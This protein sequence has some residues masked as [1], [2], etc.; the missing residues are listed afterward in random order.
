MIEG[1]RGALKRILQQNQ[2]PKSVPQIRKELAG[3]FRISLKDL[4]V[5]LG[6]MTALGE[7]FTWPQ[8]K[9]WDR[10]PR[11]VLP[12]L[13]LSVVTKC[14]V[15]SASKIKTGLKLPLEM[16]ETALNE[17]ADRGRLYLWQPG[18]ALYFCLSEPRKMAL[19]TTLNALAAG[20]L[21]ETELI[22]LLR[23]RLP[24]YRA[25]D[26]K[27]LLSYSKRVYEYPKYG[28]VKTKYGLEPPEPG[29]YLG[30]AMQEIVAVQRLLAHFQISLEAIHHALGRELGLEHATREP[31]RE[32]PKGEIASHNAE[33]FILEAITRV[34]PSG[35]RR[36]LVSVRELRRSVSLPKNVFDR[37][38][39]SL[40]LQGKVA[41][42]HHDFPS[43]LSQDERD[44]LVRDQE[45]TYYVG[46]VP[47][48]TP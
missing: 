32:R 39:L 20:P 16:V 36:A 17:L 4:T 19:E 37:A 21:T 14:L 45:G 3:S 13:I 44:E 46:I 29:P 34:Q 35:Q 38:V 23:K 48:E 26:L 6:E 12:D 24:G 8:K 42:H 10:D 11:T 30:K 47:K 31:P 1:L 18:K 41:L 2:A 28:K 27:E 25:K 43:S 15:A 5:L 7:I 33:R 9:F 40:A 22:G